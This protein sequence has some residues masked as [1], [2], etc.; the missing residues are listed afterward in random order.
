MAAKAKK[1]DST[2]EIEKCAKNGLLGKNWFSIALEQIPSMFQVEILA[3]NIYAQEN[4]K[5]G[6]RSA[7]YVYTGKRTTLKTLYVGFANMKP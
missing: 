2:S 3:I 1:K 5:I 4:F 7:N 6:I